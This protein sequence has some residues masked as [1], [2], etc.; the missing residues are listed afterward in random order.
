[1]CVCIRFFSLLGLRTRREV[2]LSSLREV[3]GRKKGVTDLADFEVREGGAWTR[4]YTRGPG[5]W[6]NK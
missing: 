4:L 3:V 6:S 5:N 2:P 1:M